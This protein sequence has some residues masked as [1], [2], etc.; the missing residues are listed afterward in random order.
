MVV[1]PSAAS[2]H[3]A[4]AR[5]RVP[6][7]AAALRRPPPPVGG[8]LEQVVVFIRGVTAL[9]AVTNA[10]TTAG[11]LRRRWRCPFRYGAVR[12]WTPREESRP[13]RGA[14]ADSGGSAAWRRHSRGLLWGWGWRDRSS[15]PAAWGVRPRG[16]SRNPSLQKPESAVSRRAWWSCSLRPPRAD[17]SSAPGVRGSLRLRG[18]SFLHWAGLGLFSVLVGRIHMVRC[19]VRHPAGFSAG[20]SF[21]VTFEPRDARNRK[22]KY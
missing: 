3:K 6:A 16:W 11:A 4:R 8:R 20:P 21:L 1:L 5:L 19:Y 14:L 15:T 13:P 12:I 9:G 2:G 10:T 7:C 22:I 18:P 17:P